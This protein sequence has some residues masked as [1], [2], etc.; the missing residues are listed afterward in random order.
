VQ[1]MRRGWGELADRWR[2]A[3]GP[4][5]RAGGH[6]YQ[7]RALHDHRRDRAARRDVRRGRIERALHAVPLRRFEEQA[8]LRR[9]ALAGRFPRPGANE[10]MNRKVESPTRAT[11]DSFISQLG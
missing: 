9:L 10:T 8:V 2:R 7:R 1:E 11:P 6:V 4:G 3:P 5:P